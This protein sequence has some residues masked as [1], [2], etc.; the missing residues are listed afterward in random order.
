M[1]WQS[2]VSCYQSINRI[3][4]QQLGGHHFAKILLNSIDLPITRQ[5][6]HSGNWRQCGEILA[7]AALTLESAGAEFVVLC[8]NT[9]H[10]VAPQIEAVL[11]IPLL[12]IADATAESIA[13]S[14]IKRV[15]LLGTRFTVEPHFYRHR[16]EVQHGLKVCVPAPQD[17]KT[18][19]R[20]IY[21]ELCRGRIQE[22]SRTEYIRIVTDM[23]A[24]GCQ[25]VIPGCTEIGLL[26]SQA[27]PDVPLSETAEIHT[28]S[29]ALW[30]LADSSD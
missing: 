24:A 19:H 18:V 23:A 21:D 2:T 20:V 25:A 10:R 3:T 9:M 5:L 14:G 4:A 17:R 26:L 30:S 6:Q 7:A 12:H 29:A 16:M 13:A 15:G 11:S 8:T 22:C 28:H 1:S 27:D